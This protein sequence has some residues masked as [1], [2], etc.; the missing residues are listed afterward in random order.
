MI[1]D[2]DR[3]DGGPA[4]GHGQGTVHVPVLLQETLEALD[5]RPGLVVVDGTA[6]AAGHGRDI[7]LAV[8]S[9]GHYVGLDRDREIL[10][11]AQEVLGGLNS[12]Q[13]RFSLHS[14]LYSQMPKVLGELGLATCDRVLLDIGASSMQFDT[15]ERG[16]AMRL[17]GPL[18]MRMN[19]ETGQTLG[20]WLARVK[21]DELARVIYEYGEERHSRRIAKAIVSARARG[22]LQR[23]M[24]LADVIRGAVSGGGA[25]SK[26][27]PATRTFQAFRIV[28]ND[29]L[30]ELERGLAAALQCLDAG[31]RLVVITFHS[32]E[33][34][35]V[36]RFLRE[37]M[38][39][40]FRKPVIPTPTE[41]RRN[42]RAR[43]AKLRCGVKREVAAA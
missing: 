11:R 19:R 5:L 15:P 37:H 20:Q 12:A 27:D 4:A 36:K 8:G 22:G 40:P 10:A 33:D 25:R 28:I 43:S 18:D 2:E 34:R 26:I 41:C 39:L 29:E 17:D 14:A 31:G 1:P 13:V 35:I 9:E 6:G 7:A 42:P 23:T 24:E 38:D 3:D 32:L 16:F 21:E 30:G